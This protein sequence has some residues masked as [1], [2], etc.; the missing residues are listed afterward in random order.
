MI[1]DVASLLVASLMY[2]SYAD[3]SFDARSKPEGEGTVTTDYNQ[4][5]S[6]MKANCDYKLGATM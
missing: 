2:D 5:L 4:L 3:R 1:A 6:D